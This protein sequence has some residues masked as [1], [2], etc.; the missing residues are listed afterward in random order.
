MRK[1]F[2]FWVLALNYLFLFT[3]GIFGLI[4]KIFIRYFGYN[5]D[6]ETIGI[7][8]ATLSGFVSLVFYGFLVL[9]DTTMNNKEV[10]KKWFKVTWKY[11]LIGFLYVV[12]ISPFFLFY[13]YYVLIGGLSFL[14][15]A[16]IGMF[17][18]IF[19]RESITKKVFWISAIL[20][21][22]SIFYEIIRGIAYRS[23]TNKIGVP[24]TSTTYFI[25]ELIIALPQ[26]IPYLFLI[27]FAGSVIA[28]KVSKYAKK[29]M[30]KD[31]A[32]TL[33][34]IF[35]SLFF[36][37]VVIDAFTVF[38]SFLYG[39]IKSSVNMVVYISL[40]LSVLSFFTYINQKSILRN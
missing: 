15:A 1:N 36:I 37:I 14:I 30:S 35:G 20:I 11:D 32:I 24:L 19:L 27:F 23:E 34:I 29:F 26:T 5:T 39:M 7:A 2:W 17:V 25:P 16:N 40:F 6:F 9:S 22:L 33:T 12:A 31:L 3:I 4:E 13:A 8:L 21:V 18:L 10:I 28:N 38:S